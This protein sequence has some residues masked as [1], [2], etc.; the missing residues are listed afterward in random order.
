MILKLKIIVTLTLI[1]IQVLPFYFGILYSLP[2]FCF[3]PFPLPLL[4]VL[5]S[6]FS[7][8]IPVD[9]YAKRF[10]SAVSL[11]TKTMFYSKILI[12]KCTNAFSIKINIPRTIIIRVQHD[13]RS[14]FS[15]F[16]ICGC[17]FELPISPSF[18][19]EPMLTLIFSMS[20][21]SAGLKETHIAAESNTGTETK[22]NFQQYYFESLTKFDYPRCSSKA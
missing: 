6:H 3:C 16:D 19:S 12:Y 14:A 8:C 18:I 2:Q 7:V 17:P 20:Q 15:H 10:N 13:T 5:S 21:S 9:F 11:H 22:A 4:L 1:K